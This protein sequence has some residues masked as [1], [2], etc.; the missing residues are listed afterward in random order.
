MKSPDENDRTSDGTLQTVSRW[1]ASDPESG[2]RPQQGSVEVQ[3]GMGW[4]QLPTHW[5]VSIL[6]NL[7]NTHS[8][9]PF[10][11]PLADSMKA[12]TIL[13]H[14]RPTYNTLGSWPEPGSLELTLCTPSMITDCFNV[15]NRFSKGGAHA[16]WVTTGFAIATLKV[17][18]FQSELLPYGELWSQEYGDNV[19][20]HVVI[21][22]AGDALYVLLQSIPGNDNDTTL[23]G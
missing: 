14:L 2:E 13:G 17:Q 20:T 5:S 8:I 16:I 4:T 22:R 12:F 23:I 21:L 19:V 18:R 15:S 3:W 7:C 1:A 9:P 6:N 10:R 11:L